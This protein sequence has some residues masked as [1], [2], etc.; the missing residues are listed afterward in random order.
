MCDAESDSVVEFLRPR[1]RPELAADPTRLQKLIANLDSNRFQV[2]EEAT[3][4]LQAMGL[5]AMPALWKALEGNPSVEA[6]QRI[7]QLLAKKIVVSPNCL[8]RLRAMQVLERIGSKEA[9]AILTELSNGNPE[10][11]ESKEAR[12]ALARVGK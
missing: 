12:A 10:L 8:Q 6:R 9:I 5:A 11:P 2:R 7:E 3:R 4:D 1:L